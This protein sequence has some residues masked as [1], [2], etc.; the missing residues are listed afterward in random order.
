MSVL[1]TMVIS[2]P[3]VLH[4]TQVMNHFDPYFSIWRLGQVAHALTRWP[5]RLFDANIFFPAKAT[6]T[7]SDATLLEGVLGAP[8]LWA[9]V[10]PSL[11]YNLLLY[12]GIV[13][14]GVAMFVLA[15]HLTRATAPALVAV[16]VFTMLPYRI[17]HLMHLELQWSFFIPLA[18]WSVHR[19]AES[20]RWQ[21]GLLTGLFVWLQFLACIYYGVFLSLALI[22]FVPLLLTLEGHV[23]ARKFLPPLIGGGLMAI[24]LTLP[25]VLPYV[26]SSRS[27]GA[28]PEFEISRYSA[29]VV[30]YFA[31]TE[32]NRLW[33]WTS[34][35]LGGPELR[36]FPGLIALILAGLSVR[37]PRRRTVLLYVAT[38]L[39]VA[40]LSRGLNSPLY[41]LLLG[42]ISALQGFRALARFG[43][44]VGLGVSI[45]AAFGVQALML[46]SPS[47]SRWR[48]WLVPLTIVVL[49]LE[50]SNHAIPLSWSVSAKPAPAYE[51]MQHAEQ[52]AM[53]EFPMPKLHNMPG[54]D[55]YYQSWSI[56]HHRPLL[57][58]YS[59]FYPV[60]YGAL[61]GELI[62]FPDRRSIE[63]LQRR[64]IRFVMVHRGFYAPED[65]VALALKLAT[66]PE[67]K[68]WGT[69]KDPVGLADI[70]ELQH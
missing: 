40:E 37:H 48:L 65:Y 5:M 15:R 13:A 19:T 27:V 3:Q 39:V 4:P 16:A 31:T 63:T 67:L 60:E 8:L 1:L 32:L 2:W 45:L 14:S 69:Y 24:L 54:L 59:G 62:D 64:N 58:G 38:T 10:S 20:G 17:E 53:V 50:Y 51:V 18:L 26:E 36:L 30:S 35:L 68:P 22:V 61:L 12:F 49:T 11:T 34:E 57:N 33:G 43:M 66:T 44:I 46:R 28:R 47:H 56:W 21:Y 70:F 52:G 41:R 6:L 7:Y 55:P 9:G 25:Y 42:Q 29:S 23:P